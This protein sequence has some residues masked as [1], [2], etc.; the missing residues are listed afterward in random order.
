MV[1]YKRITLITI[2]TLLCSAFMMNAQTATPSQPK[3]SQPVV[4]KESKLTADRVKPAAGIV[5]VDSMLIKM[6]LE[7][8]EFLCPSNE[9]YGGRW[10]HNSVKAYSDMTLPS[11]YEIKVS[12]FVMPVEGRITSKYGPRRRRMH[13]GVDLSLAKGDTVVAAFDGKVRVKSFEKRGYG[14]YVVLRH[15]NGLET[16][17]GH[18]SKI[19]VD[20]DEYV[21]AGQAI[22]LGGSTGR[23]SGPHLHFEMR[24]LGQDI[25]PEHI[26]DFKNSCP[27]DDVYVFNKTKATRT[28]PTTSVA[29]SDSNQ[30]KEQGA[31]PAPKTKY[32]YHTIKQG[33]TLGQIARRYGTTVNKLCK[34]NNLR[35]TSTL[36]LGRKIKV[37]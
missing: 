28:T 4:N 9:L 5:T 30:N 36:K 15:H 21:K 24:F 22:G 29:S 37:S 16:V 17:Y 31:A 2:T 18:F 13:R 8:E 1:K 26:I 3:K 19:L 23:S 14:Y 10:N 11:N 34:L 20:Q 7:A 6:A 25:N 32:K 33:D 12:D 35:P 27:K